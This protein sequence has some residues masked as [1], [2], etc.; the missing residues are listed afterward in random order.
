MVTYDSTEVYLMSATTKRERLTKVQALIDALLLK[1]SAS[2]VDRSNYD[3]VEMDDGQT[4]V[5]TKYRS[6][7]NMVAAI[8]GLQLMEERLIARLQPRRMRIVNG[9]NFR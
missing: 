3:T 4:R 8:K 5:F 9:K 6:M 7:E 1:M 2:G